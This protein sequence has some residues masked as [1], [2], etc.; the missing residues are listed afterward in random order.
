MTRRMPHSEPRAKLETERLVVI[1][2]L[3]LLY[4]VSSRCIG[5]VVL[6]L[7]DRMLLNCGACSN[8]NEV[9]DRDGLSVSKM[10]HFYNNRDKE[11]N[12]NPM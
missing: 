7:Y 4:L 6:D 12:L 3:N 5:D 11:N 8:L 1:P 2:L 10:L 9:F